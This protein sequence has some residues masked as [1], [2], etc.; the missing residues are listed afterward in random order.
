MPVILGR[1][2]HPEDVPEVDRLGLIEV[3]KGTAFS[4]FGGYLMTIPWILVS[5]FTGFFVGYLGYLIGLGALYGFVFGAQKVHK[6]AVPVVV[7]VIITAVPIAEL[8][9]IAI[10]FLQNSYIPYPLLVIETALFS[11]YSGSFYISLIFGYIIAVAG[12]WSL[13]RSLLDEG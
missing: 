11:D 6:L 8:T 1:E 4:F 2:L 12:T 3:L 13:I 7:V 9:G 5:T 10:A